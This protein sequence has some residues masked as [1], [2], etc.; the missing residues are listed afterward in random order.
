VATVLCLATVAPFFTSLP[1]YLR[2][3][4]AVVVGCH[5]LRRL[6]AFRR[7]AV[8]ALRLSPAGFWTVTLHHGRDVPAELVESRLFGE[9]VFLHLRWRG[10][11]GQV[12]LL[13]DNARADDL[14]FLRAWLRTAV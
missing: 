13:P 14:R 7:P 6:I 3:L 1:W 9:A 4:L 10:G 11:A 2:C 12:A 8:T 5:G